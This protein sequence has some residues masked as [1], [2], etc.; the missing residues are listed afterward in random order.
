MTVKSHHFIVTIYTTELQPF[1]VDCNNKVVCFD[2]HLY[3]I[4]SLKKHIGMS[5]IKKN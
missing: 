2:C 3:V 1:S 4:L 5:C